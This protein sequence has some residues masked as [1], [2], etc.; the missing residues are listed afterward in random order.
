MCLSLKYAIYL[1]IFQLPFIT[2]DVDLFERHQELILK[3]TFQ[4]ATLSFIP[5]NA[6]KEQRRSHTQHISGAILNAASYTVGEEPLR[7]EVTNHVQYC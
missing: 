5:T 4:L 3:A 6:N 7:T 2:K 1:F